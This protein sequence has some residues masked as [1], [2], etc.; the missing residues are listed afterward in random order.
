MLVNGGHDGAQLVVVG[1][2]PP[3]GALGAQAVAAMEPEART[4]LPMIRDRRDLERC[5]VMCLDL[6]C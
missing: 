5:R 2:E 3:P 6:S 1:V 4:R